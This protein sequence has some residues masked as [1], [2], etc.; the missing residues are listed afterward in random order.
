MRVTP[1]VHLRGIVKAMPSKASA[2]Q[3][4]RVCS[5]LHL[6]QL[7][8][9]RPTQPG[10]VAVDLREDPARKGARANTAHRVTDPPR[11]RHSPHGRS[12][13]RDRADSRHARQSTRQGNRTNAR[14]EVSLS[15]RV[16][17]CRRYPFVVLVA[18]MLLCNAVNALVGTPPASATLPRRHTVP[19]VSYR[20][21]LATPQSPAPYLPAD[22]HALVLP[23]SAVGLA[24]PCA[25]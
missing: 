16:S 4:V 8:D 19:K 22:S 14:S 11:A 10:G 7:V 17:G 23:C 13:T 21:Q 24:W 15:I 1:S 18:K 9:L 20:T 2:R 3:R 6:V 12:A 25:E 5:H